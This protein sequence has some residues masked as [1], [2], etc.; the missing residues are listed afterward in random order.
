MALFEKQ[1]LAC[2]SLRNSKPA[3]IRKVPEKML[4]GACRT[5]VFGHQIRTRGLQV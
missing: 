2:V 1:K 3:F 4:V 5:F